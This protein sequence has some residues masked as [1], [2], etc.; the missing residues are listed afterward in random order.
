MKWY[1]NNILPALIIAFVLGCFGFFMDFQGL[2]AKVNNIE[3][4]FNYISKSLDEI[5]SDVKELKR[6][7]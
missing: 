1:R 6:G 7:L 3:F 5:K 4:Q 2:K